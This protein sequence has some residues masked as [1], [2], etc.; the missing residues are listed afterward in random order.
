MIF[1]YIVLLFPIKPNF[2]TMKKLLFFCLVIFVIPT[3][4]QTILTE[5]KLNLGFSGFVKNDFILDSR[6]NLEAVDGLYTLWPLKPSLDANGKDINAQPSARMFCISTRFATRLSGLELGKSKVGAYVELDFTGGDVANSVRF[7]HAY[8][9]F[10]WPKTTI[11][12][13]RTWHPTFI[14]KVFPG[15]MA[16]NTGE[17][18]QVFN[19]SEQLRITHHLSDKFDV[20]AAAVYQI[21]YI[22]YGP[23]EKSGAS[24]TSARYQRDALLP[25]LH[26]Q[27]QYYDAN[28]VAG[29]GVDWKTIQP[30]RT[31]IGSDAKTYVTTEK[32]SSMAALAY[33][34]YTKGKFEFKAKSMFGQNVSESLLP[35]G[36]AIASKNLQTGFET[37]TPTNH[38][39]SFINLMYGDIWKVGIFAGYM[40]NL[41]TSDNPWNAGTA[42]NPAATF[43]ARGSDVDVCWRIAPQLTWK[44]KNFMLSWEPEIT[45][46]SYGT[47]D[48]FDKGKVKNADFVTNY[49]SL[50]TVFYFF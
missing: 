15:V 4:A 26:L 7:R 31:T 35:G 12:F 30:R 25:N 9:T 41:G 10:T 34:K 46:A 18:F 29:A 40:K 3:F 47:I 27:F 13:G 14:E 24:V 16:L 28:W 1:A 8:T 43:Y 44:V 23:D 6:R 17:P 21:N 37:Y 32:L 33:I 49:R 11:L 19:R 38:T 45:S 42:A 36:Y 48:V 50:I 39:Y 20:M 22:N 5:K 2:L